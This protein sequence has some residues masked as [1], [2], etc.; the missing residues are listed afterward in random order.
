M[1]R[2]NSL[3][4]YRKHIEGGILKQVAFLK[5]QSDGI[6]GLPFRRAR[7]IVENVFNAR[8]SN[9]PN[10]VNNDES[11]AALEFPASSDTSR[12]S[13]FKMPEQSVK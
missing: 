1:P 6:D 4:S 13:G 10:D 5:S 12:Q 11:V 2:P 3:P 7:W 8:M 9:P